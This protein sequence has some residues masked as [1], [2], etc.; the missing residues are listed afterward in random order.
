MLLLI[1]GAP[2]VRHHGDGVG[3]WWLSIRFSVTLTIWFWRETKVGMTYKRKEASRSQQ[4]QCLAFCRVRWP[5][6]VEGISWY[7]SSLVWRDRKCRGL[8]TSEFMFPTK[9]VR[10]IN[11]LPFSSAPFHSFSLLVSSIDSYLSHSLF[12]TPPICIN[13][14]LSSFL[15]L[16]ISLFHFLLQL[17]K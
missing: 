9:G 10:C 1:F 2:K 8:H 12:V 16:C 15:S 13:P 3:R 11:A 4:S 7:T 6:S 17:L 5:F 14:S